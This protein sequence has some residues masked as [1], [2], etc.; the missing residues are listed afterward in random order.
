[1]FTTVRHMMSCGNSLSLYG[2]A[3]PAVVGAL[4]RHNRH[5]PVHVVHLHA[6]AYCFSHMRGQR[7]HTH[8]RVHVDDVLQPPEAAGRGGAG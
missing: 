8:Q 6:Q 5:H 7:H 3:L 1:M 2:K 4:Y